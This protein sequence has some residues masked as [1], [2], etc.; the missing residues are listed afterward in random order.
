MVDPLDE[1]AISSALARILDD[2][3]ER[4]RLRVLGLERAKLFHW[5]RCARLTFGAYEKALGV[6]STEPRRIAVVFDWLVTQAGGERVLE[7]VLG[8][9]PQADLFSLWIFFRR[10]NGAFW[11]GGLFA[12]SSFSIPPFC[13]IELSPLPSSYARGRGIH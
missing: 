5:D 6:K 12:T 8:L 1:S 3:A 10:T 11:E 2:S 4:V 7:E 13:P 9:F